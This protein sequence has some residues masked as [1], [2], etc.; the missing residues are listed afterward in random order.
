MYLISSSNNKTE[1]FTPKKNLLPASIDFFLASLSRAKVMSL[2]CS[3]C[4]RCLCS[5][6]VPNKATPTY[7]GIVL[8]TQA[9]GTSYTTTA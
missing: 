1:G 3:I 9:E 2:N 4:C 8:T 5:I 7:P 6:F